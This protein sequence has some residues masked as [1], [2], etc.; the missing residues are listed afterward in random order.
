M[1]QKEPKYQQIIEWV[2]ENIENGT[3]HYGDKLM[4][5]AELSSR[6]GLSRQTVRHATGELVN[7]KLV[8]RIQGSGTYIGSSYQPAREAKFMR[9][10]VVS[11]FYESYIFPPTLRGIERGLSEN[12]Y[13]MQVSFTDNR[14]GREEE[15]L[16]SILEQDNVDGLIVEPAQSA[17]PNPNL[18]YYEKIRSRN[19]PILCFNAFYPGLAAPCVRLDDEKVAYKATRLLQDAGHTRIG[20]IF[21][22]DDGQGPS[23]YEGYTKAMQEKGLH[24]EQRQILWLD[25]PMTIAMNDIEDYIFKRIEGCSAV[26]CYNDQVA[27]QLIDLALK[28]GIRVPEELSVTGID[29]SYLAGVSR[30]PFT[31]FPHPKEALGRKVAENMI[32]M[33]ENPEYNGNYLYDSEPVRRESVQRIG[34]AAKKGEES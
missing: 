11:T 17:L 5:E 21:K 6:F 27:Y 4:S 31:S 33:I 10:A 14:V 9:I 8:T 13:S 26:V 23:R 3:L 19:I 30:V 7:Q 22:A 16:R 34:K 18:K 29:D 12:G 28:R 24:V 25:T 2:K 32:R 1:A 20:G 15:I